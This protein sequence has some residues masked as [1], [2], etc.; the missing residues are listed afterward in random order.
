MPAKIVN[1]ILL[2][3]LLLLLTA[4]LPETADGQCQMLWSNDAENTVVALANGAA[5]T[6]LISSSIP[7]P[8][9]L[10]LDNRGTGTLY[11]SSQASGEIFKVSL[12]TR[13]TERIL[14][15]LSNPRGIAV[16]TQRNLLYWAETVFSSGAFSAASIKRSTLIGGGVETV[17]G[18]LPAV[19][20]IEL[21][22]QTNVLIWGETDSVGARLRE[23]NLNSTQIRTLQERTNS[24]APLSTISW[25]VG[26]IAATPDESTVY[27]GVRSTTQN[28]SL[29]LSGS[30]VQKVLRSTLAAE[31]F[32]GNRLYVPTSILRIGQGLR[33]LSFANDRVFWTDNSAFLSIESKSLQESASHFALNQF[34]TPAVDILAIPSSLSA[35]CNSFPPSA[36]NE[37]SLIFRPAFGTWYNRGGYRDYAGINTPI[38]QQFGLPGDWPVDSAANP[39]SERLKQF[40]VWR[41]SSG[42]WYSCDGNSQSF[43]VLPGVCLS[44][45]IQ[46]GL[47]GDYPVSNG[48]NGAGFAG[49]AVWRPSFGLWFVRNEVD[50]S[51][52]QLQ[53]GL[54]GDI[55]L[56]ADYDG[57]GLSDFAVW[58]PKF[59]LWFILL[60]TCGYSKD[61]ANP[62]VKQWGLPEDHPLTGDFD[63]DGISDLA[64]WR[65]ST[66][67]WYVCGSRD[68]F[69]CSQG[70][71]QQFG[72]PGDIPMQMDFDQDR[73]ADFVVWRPSFG[74]WYYQSSATSR[75]AAQQWGL[76]TDQPVPASTRSLIEQ[77]Y[78]PLR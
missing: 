33:G 58:R 54:P 4:A 78:G 42:T 40:T 60:S 3:P 12:A 22:V 67:V 14:S 17:V 24:S 32:G 2:G 74:T 38:I 49:F 56:A 57:D 77:I 36:P 25:S 59:G 55:P 76:P 15:G 44:P 19:T 10:A 63:G 51:A 21:L 28:S 50:N 45:P 64:V 20:D 53:W 29:F 27:A 61:G 5:S 62:L 9:Y 35:V 16:D 11:V 52:L 30:S 47:P 65:P 23:I 26:G 6:T 39:S 73:R 31:N 18:D 48:F 37:E 1:G 7:D 68:T 75:F 41:P 70:T 69:D 34:S 13:A 72:L 66:G 71:A 46:F 8:Q 43:R